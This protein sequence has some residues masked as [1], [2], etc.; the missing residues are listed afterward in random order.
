MSK[1]ENRIDLESE[2]SKRK[3]EFVFLFN[4][5]ITMI[6]INK[7]ITITTLRRNRTLKCNNNGVFGEKDK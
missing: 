7:E 4:I 1:F 2:L 6:E 5:D 3:G